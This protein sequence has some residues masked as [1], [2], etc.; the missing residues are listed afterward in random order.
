M[1]DGD[2][3]EFHGVGF[4]GVRGFCGGFGR[5]ALGPW[6]EK[7][8][9]DFVHEAVQ[10]ALKLESALARLKSDHRDRAHALRADPRQRSRAS[11]PRSFPSSDRAASRIRCRASTSPRSFTDT[12]TR[13]APE[14]EDADRDSGLQRRACCA[15]G[16][17]SGPAALPT[18]RRQAGPARSADRDANNR[19]PSA[20]A[21]HDGSCR[22]GVAVIRA[23]GHPRREGSSCLD[24]S[25]RSG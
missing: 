20:R 16:E 9:K 17:L 1:L 10:E 21:A 15:Q 24:P 11:R 13:A 7:I 2:T 3:W 8:I 25:R 4:A 23:S 14:G 6:G 18:V 12:R 22:A 19:S 5:G